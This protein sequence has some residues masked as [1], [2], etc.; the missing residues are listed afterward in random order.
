MIVAFVLAVV[1]ALGGIWI[2]KWILPSERRLPIVLSGGSGV[3]IGIFLMVQMALLRFVPVQAAVVVVHVLASP[4]AILT[5]I[6]LKRRGF[7]WDISR[8]WTVLGLGLLS[9]VMIG[10]IANFSAGVWTS[11]SNENL[12]VRMAMAAHMA[13]SAWPPMDPYA[14]EFERLYRYTGQAWVAALM[15]VSGGGLFEATLAVTLVSIWATVAGI[16]ATVSLMRNYLARLM[17]SAGFVMAAHS[18]FLGLW[19]APFGEF[20]PSRAAAVSWLDRGL[21]QGFTG[22]HGFALVPGNDVTLVVALAAAFGGTVLVAALITP[23]SRW[24]GCMVGAALSFGSMAVAS[25]HTLPVVLGVLGFVVLALLGRRR[26]AS[27]AI[28]AG[29]AVLGRYC[30]CFLRE[31]CRRWCLAVTPGRKRRLGSLQ[32]IS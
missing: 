31:C 24:V 21:I 22:S 12:V 25:E 10:T 19:K 3:G 27:A 23:G 15:R 14:P 18:N 8:G 26:A 13:R 5:L 4:L 20:T 6:D 32:R 2:F 28:V 17:G 11:A 9:L 30:R 29:I 16:F 1:P 7:T